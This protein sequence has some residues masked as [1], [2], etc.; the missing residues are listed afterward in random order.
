MEVCEKWTWTCSCSHR[1][2]KWHFFR[3]WKAKP[4]T[5]AQV[6]SSGVS[7]KLSKEPCLHWIEGINVLSSIFKEFW[8]QFFIRFITFYFSA[9]QEVSS[10]KEEPRAFPTYEISGFISKEPD[11]STSFSFLKNT[12]SFCGLFKLCLF[13]FFLLN[14]DLQGHTDF[15]N[16]FVFFIFDIFTWSSC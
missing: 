10:G 9:A 8:L 13:V 12:L 6:G 4:D 7:P 11:F 16:I 3:S 2:Q 5:K 14:T 15:W 1:W